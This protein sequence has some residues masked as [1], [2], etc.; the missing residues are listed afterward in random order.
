MEHYSAIKKKENLPFATAWMDLE[1]IMLSEKPGGERQIPYDF[2]YLWNLKTK[3]NR[4][5]K[6]A[7][8]PQTLRSDCGY[9]GGGGG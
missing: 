7:V 3:Q 8:D 6:T 1:R 4:M 5:N 9:H 2:T